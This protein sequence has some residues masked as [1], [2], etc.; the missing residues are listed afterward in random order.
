VTPSPVRSRGAR[1]RDHLRARGPRT[2]SRRGRGAPAHGPAAGVL[3][4]RAGGSRLPGG[5]APGSQR[6]ALLAVRVARPGDHREPRAGG[7][8]QGGD[9]VRHCD[10]AHR[11]RS[12]R[13]ASCDP[14]RRACV[15][16][17]ARARRADPRRQRD[18]RGGRGCGACR[19]SRGCCA[20]P[21]RRAR[22][23]SPGSMPSACVTSRRRSA[24]SAARRRS[25]PRHAPRIR[26]LRPTSRTS[27]TSVAR[28]GAGGRS[29]S[30]RPGRTTSSLPVRPGR[31]RRCSGGG[32]RPSFR[33]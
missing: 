3:D 7:A 8:A 19:G 33:R 31:A 26:A 24:T 27:R 30:P 5:E 6:R 28:S 22:R 18:D 16:R 13:T 17:R 29:S 4:R 25:S 14:A 21:T 20:R 15:H 10:R 9:G 32:S 11:A 12:L 23:R 2:A 1:T